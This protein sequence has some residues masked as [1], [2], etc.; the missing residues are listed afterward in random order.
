VSERACVRV[1]GSS[2]DFMIT[3]DCDIE[4]ISGKH[5]PKTF[6]TLSQPWTERL[7]ATETETFAKG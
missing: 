2:S 7:A 4:T 6:L 3:L 1:G 5:Y